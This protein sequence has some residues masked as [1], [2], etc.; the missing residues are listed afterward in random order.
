[1]III[2]LKEGYIYFVY[3]RIFVQIILI[4]LHEKS[5]EDICQ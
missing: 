2:K 4:I 3:T 5:C 1:M